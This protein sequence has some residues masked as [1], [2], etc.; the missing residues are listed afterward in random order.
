[1]TKDPGGWRGNRGTRH[2]R[3]YGSKWVKLREVVLKRDM[4]LCQP[5]L[6]TGRPTTATEVDHIK[7]KAKGGTDDP[8]NLQAICGE[9]HRAKTEREGAEAQ[10]RRL[11]RTI[12]ADGWPVGPKRFGYSIPDG[13]EP[14][15]IP[16]TLVCGPPAS[17]KSTWIKSVATEGDLVID[18]D[19]YRKA[20]GGRKWDT[21]KSVIRRAFEMRDKDIHSLSGRKAGRC[22]LIVTAP[23][24]EERLAWQR[25]LGMVDV[26]VI[27]TPAAECIARIDADPDRFEAADAQKRAVLD[28]W[29]VN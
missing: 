1:M 15:S 6:T 13:V 11:K 5:C 2:E 12:G 19:V 7:P 9:C 17:G 25:A 22:F 20:V 10:G 8:D 24:P 29:A 14:S 18:F 23:T 3:G 26:K 16:V 21:D 28:W 4:R 27:R